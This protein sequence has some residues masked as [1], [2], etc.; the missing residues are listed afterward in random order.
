MV[1]RVM[2]KIFLAAM[3][4]FIFS[5]YKQEQK[6]EGRW[7]TVSQM[8]TG[9]QVYEKN[10][11]VCHM[12]DGAGTPNWKEKLPDGSY[13][14]PPLDKTAHAWHHPFEDMLNSINNGGT[15]YGGKMPPFKDVL[16]TE[17]KEAVIAYI[18]SLW[19]DETYKHWEEKI[20]K[21]QEPQFK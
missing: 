16:K 15:A 5:C 7:Y 12:A 4:L 1:R 13:P 6:V 19:P 21:K 8:E 11:M 20:N 3:A 10:C 18:H 2:K 9:K 14:P 17:E